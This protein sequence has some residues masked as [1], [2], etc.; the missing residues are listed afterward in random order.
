MQPIDS[1]PGVTATE[2]AAGSP[3][4]VQVVF[5]GGGAKL[6]V[7]MAV[8]EVLKE[9]EQFHKRIAVTRVAGSSAGAIAAAM[10]SLPTASEVY[11][12]K[13]KEIAP[14]H[15]KEMKT[16]KWRGAWRV[17]WGDAFFGSFSLEKFFE[18]FFRR[19]G[20]PW[21]V[22]NL[23]KDA[24]FYHTDLYTLRA[25][26]AHPQAALSKA[27]ADSCRFPLAFVG[28]GTGNTAVDGGLAINLPVDDLTNDISSKGK[29]LAI[30][31]SSSFA[32]PSRKSLLSY[33]QQLFSAAIQSGVSRSEA[34]LGKENVFPIDTKIET[35]D[36]EQALTEGLDGQYKLTKL[37][38]TTWLDTWLK[39]HGP[40]KPVTP[41]HADTLIRPPLSNVRLAP[42][43]IREIS[44][45]LRSAPPTHAV[46]VGAY[47]TA[48]LDDKGNFT[49]RYRSSATM[50]F[51]IIRPTS[52]LQFDTQIGGNKP[53][54]A[55]NLGCAT[56]DKEGHPLAYAVDVQELSK[57]GGALRTFRIYIMFD[58]RLTV[59][60]PNQPY[61]VSYEYES[62]DAYPGLGSKPESATLFRWGPADKVTLAV[63]FPRSRT[64]EVPRVV[65]IADATEA[66]RNSVAFRLDEG[67]SLRSSRKMEVPEYVRFLDLDNNP[68]GWYFFVGRSAEGMTAG[69]GIGF[70]IE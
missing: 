9:Y 7:L 4:P 15:L 27:L 26:P 42:A 37:Q 39:D 34:I 55:A 56:V 1:P 16:W 40:R 59:E 60:S 69:Q 35:F 53:F 25:V 6:C 63:A 5:Q 68:P 46:E 31:F 14:R 36:F 50:R 44:D 43:M 19:D 70:I 33:T 54:A 13:L 3:V 38:F 47:K 28:F 22:G 17:F 2:P 52:V 10:L 48:L 57:I 51:K 30:G 29:V 45:R 66:E 61:Y 8:V 21:L 49:G 12:S 18:E 65:D 20:E 32:D 41:D 23:P 62:D 11:K 67:E 24:L 58:E 64:R